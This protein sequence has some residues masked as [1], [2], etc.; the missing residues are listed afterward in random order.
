MKVTEG[1]TGMYRHICIYIY[2]CI[3]MVEDF[4]TLGAL[5]WVFLKQRFY[6]I[7]VSWLWKVM[8]GRTINDFPIPKR[9]EA[10]SHWRMPGM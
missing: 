8:G 1:Y 9:P 6:C 7:G 5:L 10:G 4:Q 2:I 3:H